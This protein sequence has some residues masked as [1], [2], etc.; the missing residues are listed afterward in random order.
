MA[1]NNNIN[2]KLNFEMGDRKAFNELR[3]QLNEVRQLA[4]SADFG[5]DTKQMQSTLHAVNTLE[6]A[7]TRAYDPTLNTVNIQ[8]FNKIL[9]ESG[10]NAKKLQSELSVVGS[11]GQQAFLSATSQLMKFNTATMQTNK[12][13]NNMAQTLFNTVKY[14][15]FN[16]ILSSISSTVSHAYG[17]VKDLDRSLNDI[18]IVT[19]KSAEDMAEF[20]T[21]ANNAAKALAVT[22]SD[23]TEGSLIYYQQGLDDET[24]KTLTDITA[25][26]SNVT[27]QSMSTV[28]E[29]LTAVQ[30]GYQVAN[31][32]AEEGMQVYEEYVDKMAAVGA[33]TAS[34]LEELSTAMS[35]VASAASSMGVGFDDLNAQIA[36]IVSVTRQAPE[37]VGTALK[38]IYARLGDLKVDGFDEF[39]TK[40]GEVSA[41]LQTMG[42]N[43]LD[44]QGNMR[45]MS[46]VIAEVAEKQD[47]WTSAQR[48]AAAVA[49]AG[50]RQYNNLIA[51][52]DNQE[53]YGEALETSMNAAGTLEQQ[54]EI[55]LESLA[56][57]MDI[58]RAT[59]ED[60]YDS[61]FNTDT[62]G[63]FVDAGTGVLQFLADFTDSVGGLNNILPMLVFSMTQLFSGQ[64][65]NGIGAVVNNLRIANEQEQL[66]AQ[67]AEQ[68]KLMFADSSLIQSLNS[69]GMMG[70]AAAQ[71]FNQLKQ[72]YT[73][74]QQYQHLMTE[75][76]KNQYNEI[77]NNIRVL[78]EKK[79]LLAEE[80]EAQR[81]HY[82]SLE[83]IDDELIKNSE[84]V[85]ELN[86][87]A[88][89]IS[90]IADQ[91]SAK[92]KGRGLQLIDADT[93]KFDSVAKTLN[94]LGLV[95]NQDD[96]VIERLDK[97]FKDLNSESKDASIALQKL[98][99]EMKSVG[100]NAGDIAKLR[101]EVV[102]LEGPIE[103]VTGAMQKNFDTRLMVQNITSVI[104]AMGQLAMSINTIKNL[105]S[106][107]NN[108]DLSTG[109]KILQT[110]MNL[111]FALPGLTTAYAAFNK[112]FNFT[113]LFSVGNALLER[114]S[115]IIAKN[116]AG[117]IAY[118]TAQK[119]TNIEDQT[120]LANLAALITQEQIEAVATGKDTAA[121]VANALSQKT[122][123]RLTDEELIALK[124][125][126]SFLA[127]DTTATNTATAATK[128]FNASILASP[129]GIVIIALTALVGTLAIVDAHYKKVAESARK[130][131]EE[132]KKSADK[133]NSEAESHQKLINDFNELNQQ[134]KD[135]LVEKEALQDVTDKL[136]DAY[137]LEVNIV[138]KLTGN[139]DALA[140]A[141]KRAREE[142]EAEALSKTKRSIRDTGEA[143]RRDARKE[144]QQFTQLK[145]SGEGGGPN[146]IGYGTP[147]NVKK[148]REEVFGKQEA[149]TGYFYFDVSTTAGIVD[150]VEKLDTY[151]L[152]MEEAGYS[153]EDFNL[154]NIKTQRDLYK[155]SEQYQ[156]AADSIELYK[157]QLLE[158]SNLDI[159]TTQEDFNK[160]I[161]QL[162]AD[163]QE[164]I[165]LGYISSMS[166]EEL[167]SY[168]LKYVSK[169]NT[170]FSEKFALDTVI[171]KKFGPELVNKLSKYS[172]EIVNALLAS[173]FDLS[174]ISI[175][176]IDEFVDNFQ[177]SIK[178]NPNA[179]VSIP[180]AFQLDMNE[181]ILGGKDI[182]KN[183]QETLLSSNYNAETILGDRESF[184][185]KSI[186]ERI[187]LM[188]QL[189][190]VTLA[191]NRNAI[192]NY[193]ILKK[194]NDELINEAEKEIE[195]KTSQLQK[196]S[197][198]IEYLKITSSQQELSKEE[199]DALI[200]KIKDT[201][202]EIEQL[203][204]KK[205]ELE[206][207]LNLESITDNLI[208]SV[209]GE[210][211]TSADQVK[212]AAESIGEGQKVAAEDV[213]TFAA[214]FPEL[215][216]GVER[217]ADGS[218]QLSKEIVNAELEGAQQRIDANKQ[219]AIQ[220]A[221]D[222]IKQLKLEIQF[223]E[224]QE[225]ILTEALEGEKTAAEV[226]TE[227]AE[228]TYDYQQQLLDNG[229]IAQADALTKSQIQEQTAVDGMINILQGLND[230]INIIHQNFANML[231]TDVDMIDLNKTAGAVKQITAS[232]VDTSLLEKNGFNTSDIDAMIKARDQLRSEISQEK[233]QI[234]SYEGFI[235]DMM[236]SASDMDKAANR[237]KKGLAGKEDK[238]KSG[239]SK[240]DK[241]KEAKE[242]EDEFDRYWEIKKAIDAVDQ[243]LKKLDKDKQNLYGYELINALKQENELLEQQ[244]ANY[245]TLYEMQ[246]Q[247]AAELREQLGSMGLMFDASGAITNYAAATSA[248]LA[249]Y[250]AAIEQYNAGLID[251]TTL[252]VYE[253]A[254]ENFKK[255]LERYDKLYYTEMQQT[256]EKLDEIRRKELANNL[257]AWEVEIQIHLDKEK[258]K[259]D[260]NDFLKDIEQD[261]KKVYSDLRIDVKFDEKNFKS[262]VNDVGTTIK[263]INDVEAEIDKMANGGTST[264]FESISQAQEKLKELQEQL[265]D[266]GKALYE[267]Y[268]Q[269]Q[270]AYLKGIDQVKDQFEEL[271]KR[272]QKFNDELEFQKEL[273][274]LLYGDKAYDLMDK[275]Y[276]AQTKNIEAQ[277]N[278][279]RKQAEYQETEFSKSFN[280]AL[281]LGSD[282]DL[283]DFTTQTEDMKKAYENMIEAQ[284]NLN[285]LVL[286]G[287]KILQDQY[288]NSINK[289]IDTMNQGLQGT[290][291]EKMK[292]DWEFQKEVSD[293]FLDNT[294]KAYKL[295]NFSNKIAQDISNS[296]SLK[297][298]EKLQ[299]FRERELDYLENKKNLTQEDIE[300]AE[301]RY[302]IA[303]KEIALEDAQNNK[304]SMKL[305][306]NEQGNWSY[307]YVADEDDTAQKQ[308]DLMTSLGEYYE[309]ALQYS[310]D[311]GDVIIE[312]TEKMQEELA[313]AQLKSEGDIEIYKQREQEIYEKYRPIIEALIDNTAVYEREALIVTSEIFGR[314]CEDDATA[315]E[316]LTDEQQR[317]V[318]EQK[319]VTEGDFSDLRDKIIDG[320]YPD[321]ESIAK[322]VFENTAKISNATV[323]QMVR[324]QATD[325]TSFRQVIL[326]AIDDLVKATQNYEKELD[327]LEEIS[328]KDFD[329]IEK[330]I[331]EVIN[332]IDEM[333]GTTE[334]MVDN[335]SDYLDELRRVLKAVADAW[336]DVI[337]QILESQKQMQKYLDLMA[338]ARAAAN[339]GPGGGAGGGGTS[340]IGS[341]NGN[342]GGSGGSPDENN[343]Q[344]SKGTI[345]YLDDVKV[346]SPTANGYQEEQL[347]YASSKDSKVKKY[348]EIRR[349][350]RSFREYI[351]RAEGT[352]ASGGYTGVQNN[353]DS[354]GR[355]AMLH[356]KELVLN[357][358]DTENFLT[359][360]RI[361]REMTNLN[362]SIADTITT[363]V[364][365]MIVEL[366]HQHATVQ[367]EQMQPRTEGGN[368][369]NITA[370]FPNANDVV[371][372]REAILG[373]PTLASQ[374]V[375]QNQL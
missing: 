355:L 123:I 112:V 339:A 104:S 149:D 276:S 83:L 356:Q 224:E 183:D 129:I 283:N 43:I 64:I 210:V 271:M 132:S 366:T 288:L 207:E 35:K 322:E 250:S 54:Q 305:T 232:S 295:Q 254:Y 274:E 4:A 75:E 314:L 152:K 78:G 137:G 211:I 84:R 261:F 139:Y 80:E 233:T 165:N 214:A 119:I 297:V 252:K 204:D 262:F 184:N 217:Q 28:S 133:L 9:S 175:D 150:A 113:S 375:A 369:F 196:D 130:T 94:E 74:M 309:R 257:K 337:D 248:A 41:Q 280:F 259:R 304:T 170:T 160:E 49:M 202:S 31:Q 275:Y 50:K 324:E 181:K 44:Q 342:G 231:T 235:S 105:G 287:V 331:D 272:Y 171:E 154:K 360:V 182:A 263:A 308:Q 40:L 201:K 128:A 187:A 312:Q 72:Y 363:A 367:K 66:M 216:E 168:I 95:G 289:I 296:S 92:L 177:T 351:G 32:A 325:K 36:T 188:Q 241:D 285:D 73:E 97:R 291:M 374:Y 146:E 195:L 91:L 220:A 311:G 372:I 174:L 255:L 206:V 141:A 173:G 321:L 239:S 326:S 371:E 110:V 236:K 345:Q 265:L 79:I 118:N 246:Q 242:Q 346:V 115:A 124:S 39:G 273:I 6:Q 169:L 77:L 71:G 238:S 349:T 364:A 121:N 319:E 240:K 361:M 306:R 109:D 116:T 203:T 256:Q 213:A 87:Q 298:Q 190:A 14:T 307:Q 1:Q 338:A 161:E 293:L 343:G 268:K 237:V 219:V 142:E 7:L 51:L 33:S 269:V 335:S 350:N 278:S 315:Y 158:F 63:D 157:K 45:D 332:K 126:I 10:L 270:D 16:N 323:L 358:D 69:Q 327:K 156:N 82:N 81:N 108:D 53:M 229:L 131:A 193:N 58:L 145:L 227:L 107:Q 318:N 111:S 178:N 279:M 286:E 172:P 299:A 59:A 62:I 85:G 373:L 76:E 122:K 341:G 86:Q 212:A 103:N 185:N 48:Q 101:N 281:S 208:Q 34:D 282:V 25:K 96:E 209:V 359:G 148:I 147:D 230:S 138:D 38:T 336:N 223:K 348:G 189:N 264:M 251:E 46:G 8:K 267:L 151:I 320:F 61:L 266:Q 199:Q 167:D 333:E 192:E 330:N 317:M 247:E 88:K 179:V 258:M 243:A 260:W 370:E 222:K 89:Q 218:L 191:Q 164:G 37:S 357:A 67:N 144:G 334:K 344:G 198:Y 42:I 23:Y 316:K 300:L 20:A 228:A 347:I 365:N 102:N 234:A 253:K 140:D 340:P 244:A 65:A 245:N 303:L 27:Q 310:R 120:H 329:N 56:N 294:Q 159:V 57:K 163:F 205:Y 284:G 226:K 135:G 5:L 11:T 26:T 155:N 215:M 368:I 362:G 114:R 180:A 249:Q 3:N 290:S 93:S 200:Q 99:D 47:T 136:I 12:F 19:N 221:E 353:G 55:A 17:Y 2:F 90:D 117:Q 100:T 166:D 18:R 153:E 313:E 29:Q 225:R 22:T 354:D 194:T 352:F 176:N 24:V 30:N 21:Q 197:S 125:H 52:F 60:L 301:M 127:A 162:K 70:E 302:Q 143:I 277:I 13:L 134:Y 106:I 15:A 186:G 98:V 292:K 328:G 68:L